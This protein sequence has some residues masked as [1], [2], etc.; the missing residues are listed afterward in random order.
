MGGE[1]EKN[2]KPKPTLFN[3]EI[4]IGGVS[5]IQKAVFA[6]NI[7]VMLKAGLAI[8]ECIEIAQEQAT[9]KFSRVLSGV[10]S[11]I[12]SGQSLSDSFA[13]YPRIFSEMF[14]NVVRAGEKSGNLDENIESVAFH[15][16]KERDLRAKIKGAMMY[17]VVVLILAFSLG[18]AVTFFILPKITPLF[19]GMKVDLPLSTRVLIWISHLVNN[20]GGW[21]LFGIIALVI[22]LTWLIKRK[23]FQPILHWLFLHLPVVK[24]IVIQT[25]LARFCRTLGTMLKSGLNIDEALTIVQKVLGNYYFRQSMVNV[26]THISQGRQLSDGLIEFPKLYPKLVTRMVKV[27]EKSG[28]LEETLFYLANFYEAE[29][30]NTTKSLSVLIEP[31][32]LIVIGLAVAFLAL[33]IITPIYQITGSMRR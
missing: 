16:E 33:S 19:E 13:R 24:K 7:A 2:I 12:E 32:L 1:K 31:I 18:M 9:G 28:K 17:P 14:I 27:G 23:F 11:S 26:S 10:L 22:F 20:Y 4:I 8:T 15:L 3:T 5:L 29:V 21:L 25:N 30:D 6:K